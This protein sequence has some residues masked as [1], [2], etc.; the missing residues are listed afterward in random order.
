MEY[1]KI[2]TLAALKNSGWKSKSIKEEL[3]D[4]LIKYKKEKKDIFTDIHGY[5]ETV[6]PDL[7]RA[8]LSK[9]DINFLGLRGQA[10]TKIAR[11]LV[12]LLDEYIPIVKGSVLNEDPF[13]PITH[14]AKDLI[15]KEGES[16]PITWLH[17]SERFTE[18]LAT[19]DVTVPDLIGDID[20]IK[21]AN[22]KLSFSDFQV[23]NYGLIPRSN[24]CIFVINEIPD[25]QP[26]IQVSLFNILQ[27]NDIQIRGFNFRMPLDIHFVFTANPEDYTNRGN[28]VTPLKDRIGSQILTH[29]PKNIETSKEIT[30]QENKVNKL[31]SDRIHV[32]ELAKN[33]IEQLAFEARD[34]EY[35]DSKS[36]VSARL[37]IAA[38]EYMLSSAERR[39]YLNDEKET[40]I[41]ISDFLSI[42][43][44]VNGKL[45]LVY[46]G[47]QE[48]SYIVVLN[49]I[50][51]TI[52]RIFNNTFPVINLK[53]KDKKK[54]NPYKSIQDWFEKNK[55]KLRNDFSNE[56]YNNSL[57]QI[58]GLEEIVKNK[59]SSISPKEINFY[60][61][62]LLHGIAENSLISKKYTNTSIDFKDLISDIFSGE[63][64][65]K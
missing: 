24:R 1:L 40:V 8:I 30:K 22:L 7:E 9:H 50:S 60:M 16:T 15:K 10:K 18:K 65:L 13:K 4:N 33:M 51:K 39:M 35:V 11:E 58:R 37:T 42:I 62:F 45:E 48:G 6:I 41:R 12:E 57:H 54:H 52:K 34:Y 64:E 61:E 14:Y 26:R 44:A 47:E 29:Y 59:M 46:E 32:P 49:L 21:A 17:R 55:I 56:D 43:P 36:G 28:I 63:K 38:Y 31:V 20:P 2:T 27:E 25:L 19:P 5:E 53:S 3:R 23:I